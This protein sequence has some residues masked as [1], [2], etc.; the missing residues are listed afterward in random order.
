MPVFRC[1]ICSNETNAAVVPEI[2]SQCGSRNVN[3]LNLETKR[4]EL[5]PPKPVPLLSKGKIIYKKNKYIIPPNK[6]T[7]ATKTPKKAY[8]PRPVTP[9]KTYY[10][11]PP[12]PPTPTSLMK[13]VLNIK[14]KSLY[15]K[16]PEGKNI[17]ENIRL[18]NNGTGTLVCIVST[19][20]TW[21]I[22]PTG[23]LTFDKTFDYRFTIKADSLL[24]GNYSGKI[25]FKSTGGDTELEIDVDVEEGSFSNSLKYLFKGW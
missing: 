12:A 8:I 23:K 11:P 10:T 17:N 20:N 24:P 15:L 3:W 18:Y 25:Y 7:T 9:P 19:K 13:T 22:V 2:C 4:E 5:I 14:P 16:I 21:I 6:S 1:T